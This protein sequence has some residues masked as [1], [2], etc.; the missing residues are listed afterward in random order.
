VAFVTAVVLAVVG[1]WVHRSPSG[2]LF[3]VLLGIILRFPHP[4]PARMEPLGPK[5]LVVAIVT[6]MV[7][8]LCFWPFPITIR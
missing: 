6:L 2:F 3:A 1:F 5:R 7:Y 8:A 4:Q